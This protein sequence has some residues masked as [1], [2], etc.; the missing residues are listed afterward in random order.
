MDDV[1]P[2]ERMPLARMRA[3]TM[4]APDGEAGQAPA[5]A[6]LA[7]PATHGG[8]AVERFDTHGASVFLAGD[9]AYKLKRAVKFPFLDFSTLERRGTACRAEVALNRRTA[10]GLYL[11]LGAVVAEPGGALR[12]VGEAPE[13]DAGVV[14]YVV[15]MRRFDQADL[16]DRMADAGT[17]TEDLARTLAEVVAGF[18]EAAEPRPAE[19]GAGEARRLADGVVAELRRYPELFAAATVDRVARRLDRALAAGHDLLD[20][21]RDA[22][23]VRHCHG[24]LHLRNIVMQDG[25][26]VP[27]DCIEFDERL[28]VSDVLYDLAFLLMDLEHRRLRPQAN[29]LFNRYLELTGDLSGLSLLPLFMAIRAG[30]RAHLSAAACRTQQDAAKASSLGREAAAYLD[31]AAGLLAPPPARLVAIGG[32]SGTGKTTLA[33]HLAP[34]LGPAPGAVILRSDMLRKHLAGVGEEDHLPETA[35]APAVTERVY[36]EIAG[37][38]GLALEGRHAVVCD[39]VYART[40]ERAAIESAAKAAGVAFTGLW[41]VA[42]QA[43]QIRRVTDRRHDASDA[44]AAVVRRQAAYDLGEMR[45]EVIAA[46]GPAGEVAAVASR[47]VA[48]SG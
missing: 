45:W 2:L 44:D 21:R 18:H 38:A 35:Y 40:E 43:T 1:S 10:P 11:G 32:L 8:C 46:N 17:L 16:L 33:R 26:P 4:P 9:R 14:D 12:L 24:D 15:V 3:A 19:G 36:G 20:R 6:L 42:D 29:A 22:G 13:G 47:L 34:T 31:L 23:Y 27:F 5:F 41:L 37:R 25:R 48:A 30:I 39:A 7:D 28:A